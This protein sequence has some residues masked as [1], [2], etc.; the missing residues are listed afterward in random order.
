MLWPRHAAYARADPLVRRVVD[1]ILERV[2]RNDADELDDARE[3]LQAFI[4]GWVELQARHGNDLKYRPPAMVGANTPR[5][6]LI[7]A[8]EETQQGEFPRATLNSLRD[9]E[10]TSGLYF[11]NFQRRLQGGRP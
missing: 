7:Q 1:Y 6:W 11:K 2:K 3:R 5:T 8:A 4:D 9:V 10:K